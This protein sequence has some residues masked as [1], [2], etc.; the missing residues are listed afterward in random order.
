[1]KK[2]VVERTAIIESGAEIGEGCYIGHYAVI[3]P[4]V[5]IGNHS[6]IRAHCFIAADAIIGEHTQ[7]MQFSNIC[8]ECYIGNYV[9]VG[10][11]CMTTNTK[12]IAYKRDYKDIAEPP[13]IRYGARIGARVTIL[14]GVDIASNTLIGAGSLVSKSTMAGRMYM[15]H[16]AKDI[17]KVPKGELI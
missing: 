10:M 8:R 11:G 15:G 16:P 12:I 14:P 7:I 13:I 3:R 17:G 2:T 5:K 4:G 6:Q 9:F 1:M